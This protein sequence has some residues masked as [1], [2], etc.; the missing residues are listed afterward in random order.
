VF[1]NTPKYHRGGRVA[2]SVLGKMGDC[3]RRGSFTCSRGGVDPKSAGET[4]STNKPTNRGGGDEEV[5][6]RTGQTKG[7]GR[8]G[9]GR[10]EDEPLGEGGGRC[11]RAI[12]EGG[13][14]KENCTGG[15]LAGGGGG[16]CKGKG[17]GEGRGWRKGVGKTDKERASPK[18]IGGREAEGGGR[19]GGRY[20]SDRN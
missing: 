3:S 12:R 6:I 7:A 13:H 2:T 5:T 20:R 4:G 9:E 17:G 8:R 1:R 10:W 19:T 11:P 15:G 18:W 16:R 14:G